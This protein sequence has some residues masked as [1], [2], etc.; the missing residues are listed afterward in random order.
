[1]SDELRILRF[2]AKPLKWITPETFGKG[3]CARYSHYM[4]YQRQQNAMII[5]G[6]RNDELGGQMI[7]G[8]LYLLNLWT[9][10]WQAVEVLGIQA[11]L[12]R[13]AFQSCFVS[14][15]LLVFGGMAYEGYC[16][17]SLYIV[18]FNKEKVTKLA[19]QALTNF[20]FDSQDI[21]LAQN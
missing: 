16:N 9:L 2:G 4:H 7:L 17:S 1:V 14:Q 8:D 20:V 3:P 18:E 10:N 13:Y 5:Y 15:K 21:R 19:N 12:C 6:G 11:T